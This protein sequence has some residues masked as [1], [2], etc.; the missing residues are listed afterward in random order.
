M[1]I[2]FS[3]KIHMKKQ[4]HLSLALLVGT[5][6]V[7]LLGAVVALPA[8]TQMSGETMRLR[9]TVISSGPRANAVIPWRASC[10]GQWQNGDHPSTPELVDMQVG[11]CVSDFARACSL[12]GVLSILTTTVFDHNW[13]H[14]YYSYWTWMSWPNHSIYTVQWEGVCKRGMP[15]SSMPAM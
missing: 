14:N 15:P 8:I 13:D 10:Y 11:Y 6:S 1:V 5:L 12:S 9:G 3:S 4:K 2:L 7:V